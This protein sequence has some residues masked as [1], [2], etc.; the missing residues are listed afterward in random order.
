MRKKFQTSRIEIIAKQHKT[1]IPVNFKEGDNVMVNLPRRSSKLFLKFVGPRY[2]LRLLLGK[3]YEVSY[4]VFNKSQIVHSLKV[5]QASADTPF[6]E[7]ATLNIADGNKNKSFIP[8]IFVHTLKIF[9][10][11]LQMA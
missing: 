4:P 9:Y 8:I 1:T 11:V 6:D 2:V 10:I 3:K 7:Q 5:T